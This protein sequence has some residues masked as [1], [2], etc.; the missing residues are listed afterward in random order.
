MKRGPSLRGFV[1]DEQQKPEDDLR[2]RLH[3]METKIRRMKEQRNS[4]NEDARR[5]ADSRNALQDQS[6]DIR[7]SIKQKLDE[8]K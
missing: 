5:A 3:A 6:K 1:K 8:Q 2:T 4:F 7:E